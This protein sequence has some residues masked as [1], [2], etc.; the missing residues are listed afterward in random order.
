MSA[1]LML[2]LLKTTV[3]KTLRACVSLCA[4][5]SLCTSISSVDESL[6]F[7]GLSVHGSLVTVEAQSV[8]SCDPDVPNYRTSFILLKNQDCCRK[9]G[10]YDGTRTGT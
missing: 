2:A 1:S 7:M 5:A 6:M 9:L 10:R 8:Q 4:W 3:L